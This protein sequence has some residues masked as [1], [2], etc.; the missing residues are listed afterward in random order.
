MRLVL[1]A[2][3]ALLWRHLLRLRPPA[4]A[5]PP[6]QAY[7]EFM[8]A[9]R[10]EIAGRHGGGAGGAQARAGARSE[11]G[12]NPCRD[13][14]LSCA[15][16]R[17]REAIAAAEQALSSIPTISKRTACSAS[18]IAALSEGGGS[19]RSGPNAGAVANLGHRS[20]DEDPRHAGGGDRSE[21]AADAG[22]SA[23]ALRAAPIARC[24]FSRTSSS[25]APFAAEP[26][27]HA[28]RSAALRWASRTRRSKRYEMA[29]EINPRNYAVLGDLYEQQGRW[30]DAA[31]RLRAGARQS[32]RGHARA[33]AALFRG[34]AQHCP[35]RPAAAKARDGLKDF[36]V[37]QPAGRTRPADAVARALR[38]RR[39]RQCRRTRRAAC[40][41]STRPACAACTRL[42]TRSSRGATTA[43]RRPA[44]AVRRRSRGASKGRESDAALLLSL[45]AHAHPELRST[46]ARS[47]C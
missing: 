30:A 2:A 31:A 8:L 5:P 14:R 21:L 42:P 28:R 37:D 10:L 29:A 33:A 4:P 34:A 40:S 3:L 23:A 7:F 27:A 12:G 16:E 6:A 39:S 13:R 36:L 24:R 15:P 22:A 19:R 41:R 45:L 20:P 18:S 17:R 38:A 11:V 46:T 47:A 1:A 9:R 26:Y 35:T 44:H 32:A 25:Q 43:G